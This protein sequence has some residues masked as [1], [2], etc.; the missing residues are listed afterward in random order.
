M[1]YKKFKITFYYSWMM[2][3]YNW[4]AFIYLKWNGMKCIKMLQP[5][6]HLKCFQ[7]KW[8]SMFQNAPTKLTQLFVRQKRNKEWKVILFNLII[9]V[10]IFFL[11]SFM[12]GHSLHFNYK[13]WNFFS[14]LPFLSNNFTFNMMFLESKRKAKVPECKFSNLLLLSKY[15]SKYCI[16]EI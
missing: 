6:M 8:N 3:Y 9:K 12:K 5:N 15:F 4:I 10:G 7:M 13:S 11:S 1:I 16:R 14:F 2:F